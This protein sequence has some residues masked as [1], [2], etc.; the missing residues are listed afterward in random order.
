MAA[1]KHSD[2]FLSRL[3]GKHRAASGSGY[4]RVNSVVV[5][6]GKGAQWLA[7]WE[8][9]TKP[10]FDELVA[11]GTLTAYTVQ[12]QYLA[13]MDPNTRFVVT[14]APNAESVDKVTAALAAANRKR[15]ADERAAIATALAQLVVPGANRG[16]MAR[17]SAYSLK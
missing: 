7:H 16:F 1:G 6:P 8:K 3:T 14:I 4:L 12:N 2:L 9:Y 5:Q 10:T 13:T 17:I 15:S 11:N